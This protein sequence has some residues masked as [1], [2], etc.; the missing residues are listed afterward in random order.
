MMKGSLEED[1]AVLTSGAVSSG[2]DPGTVAAVEA[3]LVYLRDR[4]SEPRANGR[5]LFE[6]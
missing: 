4:V 6:H 3:S 2:Q 5:Q 1:Q